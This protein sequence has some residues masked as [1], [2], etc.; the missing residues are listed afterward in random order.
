MLPS[1]CECC[2]TLGIERGGGFRGVVKW[3]GRSVET[4]ESCHGMSQGPV[5]RVC[6]ASTAVQ[7]EPYWTTMEDG[8]VAE[9]AA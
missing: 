5:Q 7:L 3:V 4:L 1:L 6:S 9:E 2:Y 8:A